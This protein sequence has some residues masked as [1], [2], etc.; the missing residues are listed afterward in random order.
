MKYRI[1]SIRRAPAKARR[2]I[3]PKRKKTPLLP[4]PLPSLPIEVAELFAFGVFYDPYSSH[5][6]YSASAKVRF[7]PSLFSKAIDF[8]HAF[9]LG[10]RA[11]ILE[12]RLKRSLR[13][14]FLPALFGAF[15]GALAVAF[16]SLGFVIY[17]LF[18]KDYFGAYENFAVPSFV[19]MQYSA[20]SDSFDSKYYDLHVSYKH[21]KEIPEGYVISQTPAEGVTRRVYELGEPCDIFLVI[22]LGKKTFTMNDY[23]SYNLRDAMLELKNQAIKVNVNRV[24]SS[25]AESG[26][27]I[28]TSPAVGES[29]SEEDT[30]TL[31]V[32][33]G[34]EKIYVT[35][36]NIYSLTEARAED[37]LRASGLR[38]GSVS[39]IQ[40]ERPAGTVISQSHTFG[41]ELEK[42]SE[43]SFT[44]S[45]GIKYNEKKMPDLYGLSIEQAKQKL[46]E[47]GLVVG[48]V[49]GVANGAPKGT[50]ISQS[51]LPETPIKSGII[52]IDI[53]VSS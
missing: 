10:I 5:T 20:E 9:S 36:P 4:C 49:Y 23:S 24:Y 21:S 43:V 47:Y 8:A 17:S 25:K 3:I 40:S 6:P 46:A 50:V 27:I 44:V 32:S 30:V 53:Y 41:T 51:V 1:I 11:K 13:P 7:A 12:M 29:F 14:S 42:D 22:S 26:K 16:L 2:S 28:S 38:V 37:I 39:Y 35:V 19:G 33:L 45:A 48:N 15:C 18:I 31:T 52:S 34:P